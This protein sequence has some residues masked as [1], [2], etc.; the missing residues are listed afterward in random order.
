[1]VLGVRV[2]TSFE[3]SELTMSLPLNPG[4]T[5]LYGQNGAGKSTI[6]KALQS[7]LS[8][9][10]SDVYVELHL[11]G[12][13]R[14]MQP[15]FAREDSGGL[16]ALI[17]ANW[18]RA[19]TTGTLRPIEQVAEAVTRTTSY[20]LVPVGEADP[21]WEVWLT[22]KP[23]DPHLSPDMDLADM[24][25]WELDHLLPD[26]ALW[27]EFDEV[28]EAHQ[29]FADGVELLDDHDEGD[30]YIEYRGRYFHSRWDLHGETMGHPFVGAA[31]RRPGGS[32]HG[33]IRFP[34]ED[35][36]PEL[37]AM[38][39]TTRQHPVWALL[40]AAAIDDVDRQTLQFIRQFLLRKDKEYLAASDPDSRA[41]R[42]NHAS[43]WAGLGLRRLGYEADEIFH[44]LFLSD[45]RMNLWVPDD[46]IDLLTGPRFQWQ[47]DGRPL[48]RLSD[49][50][51]R[52]SKIAAVFA[53]AQPPAG[54]AEP[55]NFLLLDEPEAGLH[56]TAET[57]MA[58]GLAEL[59]GKRVTHIIAA[60]H[61]PQMLND[62]R[63]HVFQIDQLT[64]RP[65]DD[66]RR[67]SLE[68]LGLQPSDLLSMTRIVLLVEG[69]HDQIVLDA[70]IGRE[71]A[72]LGV[73]T[74]VLHR[75]QHLPHTVDSQVLFNYTEA[76]V[77][78]MIDNVEYAHL[79]TAWET[80]LVIAAQEGPGPAGDH[81]RR[82]LPG[83]KS[84]NLFLRQWLSEALQAGIHERVHP[85]SLTAPDI[86]EYLPVDALVPQ[87][88]GKSWADL[89]TEM[90][91]A[92]A[93][94]RDRVDFKSW[95]TKTKSASLGKEDIRRA[96]QALSGRPAEFDHLLAVCSEVV[97]ARRAR[98]NCRAG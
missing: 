85:F 69:V 15:E 16:A 46:P 78:A 24:D 60:T 1:M 50:E 10:R 87:A 57:A 67:E 43:Q 59:A 75:G 76:D 21:Q 31:G 53:A 42:L 65:L 81:L 39:S 91:R 77:V 86:I 30:Q 44:A 23:R 13:W 52:W 94:S 17:V 8:G 71:L 88:S 36:L 68:D 56:R 38:I 45:L 7:A 25:V 82:E 34:C 33:P 90:A 37:T 70:L 47:A 61:S 96:A 22:T 73:I 74:I 20:A 49:A 98:R 26:P 35:E 5:V 11:R 2:T 54:A 62:H 79:A 58:E 66:T 97:S 55:L 83:G 3:G 18:R 93:S 41:R 27:D 92:T 63:S 4:L 19:G 95:L 6:I 9:Y 84:E 51:S 72:R 28:A 40:E 89:R 64:V 32:G 29:A 48:D 14:P 80:A 12:D